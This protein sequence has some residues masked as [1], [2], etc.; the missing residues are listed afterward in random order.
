MRQ[1]QAEVEKVA[2]HIV[3]IEEAKEQIAELIEAVIRGERVFIVKDD[4]YSIELSVFLTQ[5]IQQTI[6]NPKPVPQFGS[7]KG[8]I[9]FREDWETPDYE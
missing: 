5:A 4:F 2:H 1:V 7:G 8:R 9:I 3:T 6:D